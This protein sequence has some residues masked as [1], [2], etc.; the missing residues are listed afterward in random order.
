MSTTDVPS[1][2]HGV[3]ARMAAADNAG[4]VPQYAC[5]FLVNAHASL[6]W[7]DVRV[8]LSGGDPAGGATVA[9]AADTTPASLLGASSDQALTAASISAPGSQVTGLSWSTPASYAG[10]AVA[11]GDIGPGKC[12]AFWVRRLGANSAATPAGVPEQ[13]VLAWSGGTLA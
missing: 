1:G 9:L 12:R 2:L 4:Q 5:L 10:S 11:L 6:T 8:W 7:T 3:F 13:I